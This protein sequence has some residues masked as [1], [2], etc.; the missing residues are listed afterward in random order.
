M[1][2]WSDWSVGALILVVILLLGLVFGLMCF[3]AWILMLLWN[4]VIAGVFGWTAPIGF[5]V[6]F[7][8]MLL[9]N[10]LFKGVRIIKKSED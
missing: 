6:A 3:E 9:C 1:K 5:W 10:I 4:V 2:N 7:C 8:I